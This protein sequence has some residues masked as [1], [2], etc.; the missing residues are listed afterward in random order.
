MRRIGIPLVLAFTAVGLAGSGTPATARTPLS[1][2]VDCFN[3]GGY[4]F[5][6][7]AYP[8]GGTGSYSTY[9][10]TVSIQPALST[11]TNTYNVVTYDQFLHDNCSYRD[12]ITATVTVTDSGGA[13]ATATSATM[14]CRYWPD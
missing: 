6:C 12:K 13:T 2:L 1:I 14:T 8:T 3:N 10:W 11:V 5:A 9:S 4:T 7:S